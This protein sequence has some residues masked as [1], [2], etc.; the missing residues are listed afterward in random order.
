MSETVKD[1]V[2]VLVPCAN[3]AE[4]RFVQHFGTLI[5]SSCKHGYQVSQ[6]GVTERTLIHSA[7]N[8]LADGFLKTD[9]EWGFWIDSDMVLPSNTI[10]IM[11]NWAKKLN[12]KFLTGIYYQRIG[13]HRSVCMIRQEGKQYKTEYEHTSIVPLGSSNEPFKVHAAGFGCILT[14]RDIFKDIPKPYFNYIYGED[15]ECSEDFYFCIKARK[16]GISLWAI[17]ELD[18]GHIGHAPI[19]TKKDCKY[20]EKNMMKIELNKIG[21]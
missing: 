9:C 3:S 21:G 10:P 4:P 8:Y 7:R 20:D 14:H 6:V 15:G 12:A 5:A 16:A 18:C 1:S 19:I 17:P 13:S 11:I 2:A